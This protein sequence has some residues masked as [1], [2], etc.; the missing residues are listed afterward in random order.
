MHGFCSVAKKQA[1][2]PPYFLLKF[3]IKSLREYHDKILRKY[4][5]GQRKVWRI[6]S[7]KN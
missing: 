7:P 2:V 3:Y 1:H 6:P 5:Q 4:Q